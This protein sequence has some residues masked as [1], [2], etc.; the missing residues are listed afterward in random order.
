VRYAGAVLRSSFIALLCALPWAGFLPAGAAAQRSPCGDPDAEDEIAM[1]PPDRAEGVARDAQLVVRYRDAGELAALLRALGQVEEEDP[2][3]REVICLF[4]DAGGSGAPRRA[5]V[6][7]RVVQ[8]DARTLVF[9]PAAPLARDSRHFAWIARPGFDGAG[10]TERQFRTGSGFDER[11]PTFAPSR[12]AMRLSL[13]APPASCGARAGSVRVRL[14]VPRARDDGDERSV[15]LLL[16]ITRAAG[17]GGP[18]LRA[19]VANPSAGG[20]DAVLTFLLSPEEA[21]QPVC[22]ALRAVD[23]AGRAS[24]DYTELCFDPVRGSYFAPGCSAGAG[25]GERAPAGVLVAFGT[26]LSARLRRR[27]TAPR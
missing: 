14:S 8:A 25:Q 3:S 1:R 22:V 24:E 26:L 2:C 21:E 11:P 23:G 16:F 27:G 19:R 20:G 15:E 18:A 13:D 7:G 6:D 4:R 9:V 10:R 12:D 17:A 5:A